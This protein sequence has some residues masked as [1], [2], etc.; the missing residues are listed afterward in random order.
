MEGRWPPKA[1]YFWPLVLTLFVADCTTKGLAVEALAPAPASHPIAGSFVRLTLLRNPG[2]VF[3]I[4][5][6]PYVGSWARPLLVL[7]G[8]AVIGV[9]L[10]FYRVMA[11]Q[12]RLAAAALGVAVGGAIGNLVSRLRSPL[13]VVD[14]IDVGVGT[15]RFWVFNVA[16][17]GITI[18][19]LML[20]AWLFRE[21]L[22]APHR[23][24]RSLPAPPG[25]PPG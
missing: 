22:L 14:F 20:A 2:A 9:L 21:E 10:R 1:R 23:P 7:T 18:G 3:G 12:T 17:A 6:R 24:E 15:H 5:L 13:G 19:A 25:S 4:D 16:D 11:P 8:L